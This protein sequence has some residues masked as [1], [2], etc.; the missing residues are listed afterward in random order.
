MERCA[1]AR[2]CRVIPAWPRPILFP[3]TK[4]GF[5]TPSTF[6][7]RSRMNAGRPSPRSHSIGSCNVP[8]SPTSSSAPAMKISSGRTWAPWAG[9]SRRNKWRGWMPCRTRRPRIRI[10]TSVGPRSWDSGIRRVSKHTKR[11]TEKN[12]QYQNSI[13]E[14]VANLRNKKTQSTSILFIQRRESIIGF[15]ALAGILNSRQGQPAK[16]RLTLVV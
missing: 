13:F 6:L 1:A 11:Q 7:T 10:G 8:P 14:I 15:R 4:R 9:R 2:R 5:T 3:S 12:R 16:I